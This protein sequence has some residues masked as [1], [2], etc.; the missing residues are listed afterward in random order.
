MIRVLRIIR[1]EFVCEGRN[2]N[3]T[4]RTFLG[5]FCVMGSA[6]QHD[7]RAFWEFFSHSDS[8]WLPA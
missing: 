4:N 8:N 2:R 1:R 5:E 6:A 3:R 7:R